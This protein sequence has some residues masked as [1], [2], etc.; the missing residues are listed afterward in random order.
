MSSVGIGETPRRLTGWR[1]ATVWLL[2]G[3]VIVAIA[4]GQVANPADWVVVLIIGQVF[5]SFAA[6]GA[7]V[8]TRLP[9]NVVGWLLWGSAIVLGWGTAGTAYATHSFVACGGCEPASVPIAWIANVGFGPVIGAVG[10]F[11][12]LLFPNGRLPSPA[13][14]P[15]GWFALGATVLF[16]VSIAFTPG[17]IS[18]GI[19]NPL[20]IDA[21]GGAAGVVVAGV[22]V[23]AMVLALASVVWRF[24][25]ANVV[26]RQ[27]LRWFGYAGL[28]MI[29]G[30][31][32]GLV[33]SFDAGWI[34]I[35]AGLGLMPLAT[36]VAI[37]RYRLYDLDRLV[38]RTIAY[39]LVTGGLVLV[40]L[41]INLGLT[42][43]F[44]SFASGNAAVVAASTLV[45][46]VLFTPLRRRVQRLVDR[47]F[48]RPR[49]DSARTT[50]AFSERLRDEIDLPSLVTD[51]QATAGGAISASRVG[52][53]LR[54][55]A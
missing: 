43:V 42:T 16:T 52:V 50:G 17:P 51:L 39:G 33:G 9:D 6:V 20:G 21:V 40:Y 18:G 7:L 1:A 12:P 37:L 24:R 34:V 30:L 13:W 8:V 3:S 22:L 36:G 45:V 31:V 53:W 23:L 29:V 47:R 19:V 54:D 55:G 41:A 48:D 5:I 32:V 35:F 44:S 2:A 15:V 38:S 11:I 4:L 28:L 49:Y 25:H 27:Q 14:R 46:A 10:M 26:E